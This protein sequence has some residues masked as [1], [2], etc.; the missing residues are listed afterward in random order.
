MTGD[1]K[2]L[3]RSVDEKTFDALSEFKSCFQIL[4]ALCR[5]R[6]LECDFGGEKNM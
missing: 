4:P 6:G 3:R 1:L 2:F 5:V